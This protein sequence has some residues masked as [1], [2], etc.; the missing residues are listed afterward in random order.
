MMRSQSK[1]LKSALVAAAGVAVLVG[2]VVGASTAS[3]VAAAPVYTCHV[4]WHGGESNVGF[5][6]SQERYTVYVT[7]NPCLL[8]LR[9]VVYCND[10]FVTGSETHYGSTIRSSGSTYYTCD[11]TQNLV[12][13]TGQEY[14]SGQWGG[15]Q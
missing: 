1:A 13:G 6:G 12:G 15:I 3:A 2:G 8:P 7:S 14:L 10:E 5:L 9:S 4:I 11:A